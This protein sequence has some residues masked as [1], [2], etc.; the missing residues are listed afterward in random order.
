MIYV[1]NLLDLEG[2]MFVIILLGAFTIKKGILTDKGRGELT[3]L[4]LFIVFPCYILDCFIKNIGA[5]SAGGFIG[6]M[7][8]SV[9]LQAA[10]IV[11]SRLLYPRVDPKRRSILRYAIIVSNSG[12]LGFPLVGSIFGDQGLIYA[13]IFLIFQRIN[14]FSVGISY[15]TADGSKGFLRRTLTHP[16]IAATLVGVAIMLLELRP[17]E[18]VCTVLSSVGSCSTPLSMM[19]I[20]M[21]LASA[22]KGKLV[23]RDIITYS[24]LRLFLMPGGMF[25]ICKLLDMDVVLTGTAVLLTGMPAGTLSVMLGA[26]YGSDAPF[27]SRLVIFT[28]LL[29]LVT[30]P[31]WCLVCVYLV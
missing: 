19:L 12:F 15:F 22:P 16:C 14:N 9:A 7:V 5:F 11:L 25:L 1:R 4:I 13:S 8:A 20:G 23:D 21:V 10:T 17:P 3:D 28:T 2:M 24:I 31:L 6:V 27:A 29:S 18:L 26:K 30:I